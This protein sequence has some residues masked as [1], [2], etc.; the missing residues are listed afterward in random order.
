MKRSRTMEFLAKAQKDR[1]LGA[2][3]LAALE[4]GGT[5]T[6]GEVLQ[7]AKEFGYSLTRAQFE[8]EALR[9]LER[10]FEQG[11]TDLGIILGKGMKPRPKPPQSSCAKGCLSWTVN[12]HFPLPVKA[13]RRTA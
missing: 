11:E 1:K 7:I 6:A 13:R 10:R 8:R 5:V 2:R 12:Y 9:D 3:L 4:R